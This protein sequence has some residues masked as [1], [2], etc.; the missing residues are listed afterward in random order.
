MSNSWAIIE[1]EISSN[2]LPVLIILIDFNG[3]VTC[4]FGRWSCA[5]VLD[6]RYSGHVTFSTNGV[7]H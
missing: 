3:C 2:V 4:I 1:S 5:D 6:I 7:T